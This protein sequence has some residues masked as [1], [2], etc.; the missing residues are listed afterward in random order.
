MTSLLLHQRRTNTLN[1]CSFQQ[2][3]P[4]IEI[5]IAYH[6]ALRSTT[7]YLL[8]KF[9]LYDSWSGATFKCLGAQHAFQ[10]TQDVQKEYEE[11]GKTLPHW[12][13]MYD[14]LVLKADTP[15]SV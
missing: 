7:T 11:E 2:V 4:A 15:F 14:G 10:W 6:A 1:A 13:K 9:R 12:T 8:S 5:S 3:Y